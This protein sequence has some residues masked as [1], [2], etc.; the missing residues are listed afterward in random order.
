[1]YFKLLFPLMKNKIKLFIIGLIISAITV[2]LSLI[3]AKLTLEIIDQGIIAGN[4]NLVLLFVILMI[5]VCLIR[6]ILRYY[7][8]L[9]FEKS[10]QELIGNLRTYLYNKIQSLDIG[11]FNKNSTGDLMSKMTGDIDIIRHTFSWI[12]YNSF[13]AI[14]VFILTF[15]Y[16]S[17]I[18]FKLTLILLVCAPIIVF[19]NIK[20]FKKLKPVHSK[21]REIYSE[22]NST[23]QENISANR[24]VKAFAREDYENKKMKEKNDAF[25]NINLE[26]IKTWLSYYIPIDFF[27]ILL[28]VIANIFGAYFVINNELS[29]GE[30]VAFSGLTW[31]LNYPVR[32]SGPIIND[33]QRFF[34]TFE[35]ISPLYFANP[36][37]YDA[38]NTIPFNNIKGEIVFK[39]V[40]FEI[41]NT[42]I[43]KNINLTIKSGETI[44]VMGPT[45]S[46][47]TTLISLLLRLYDPTSGEIL[48]DGVNIKN[49]SLKNLRKSIG[50]SAQDVFLFSNTIEGNIAYSNPEMPSED[51]SIYST[52]ACASEFVDKM[53][54]NYLTIIGERGVGLSG[55]QKQRISLARAL[56]VNAKILIL[57][58]TTSSVDMDTEKQIQ[59]EL[60]NVNNCTKIIIA[61]RISSVYKAN[62]IIIIENGIITNI[63]THQK[64]KAKKGFYKR[65]YELQHSELN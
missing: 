1:M 65:I 30:F 13:E 49:I 10:S 14:F 17:T 3:P 15:I 58:D 57:D 28:I 39:N 50:I 25:S 8:I 32:L 20:M 47:K 27:S 23:V 35:K 56:A 26:A 45:G 63:G 62:K 6:T 51:I 43:L 64:L 5:I 42:T 46:G 34:A 44:G 2:V 33:L 40:C 24:V 55:G 48:I 61:Q 52:K 29:L 37:I 54:E 12:I 16:L 59:N 21:T 60:N 53:P 4:K 22:L 9:F 36:N 18:N 19:L 7:M 38:S 31:A 11:F 41:E